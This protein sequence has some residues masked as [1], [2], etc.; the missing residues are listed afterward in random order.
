MYERLIEYCKHDGVGQEVLW[1]ENFVNFKI[2]VDTWLEPHVW[3]NLDPNRGL[4]FLNNTLWPGQI[5]L[6][7]APMSFKQWIAL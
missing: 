3:C 5:I 2:K 6:L 1:Q 4:Y 7:E